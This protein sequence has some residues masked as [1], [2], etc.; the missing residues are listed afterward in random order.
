MNK[1]NLDFK[2]ISAN[3]QNKT[4]TAR[5]GFE[6]HV[7]TFEYSHCILKNEYLICSSYYGNDFI[8]LLSGQ[9]RAPQPQF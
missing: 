4:N 9:I 6:G 5:Y 7:S 8:P 1:L 3:F 2:K